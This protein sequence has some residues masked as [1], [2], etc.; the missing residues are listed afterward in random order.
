MSPEL[1]QFFNG[2]VA[3]SGQDDADGDETYDDH[4]CPYCDGDEEGD[5]DA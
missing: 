2:I 1:E 5:D 3:V 4:D